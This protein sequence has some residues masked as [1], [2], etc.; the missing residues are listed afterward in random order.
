MS[1]MRSVHEIAEYKP[2]TSCGMEELAIHLITAPV[3]GGIAFAR[4]SD[5]EQKDIAR[6]MIIDLFT[7]IMWPTGLNIL[8]MPGLEWKFERKLLGKRE[9]DWFRK[10]SPHRTYITAIENDRAIYHGGLVNMPGLQ[11]EGSINKVLP[12]TKFA[13][14]VVRNTWVN[15]YFF[16]NVDDLMRE[17]PE[18]HKYDAAWLDYTG[19]MSL[20]RAHL[21]NKFFDN[22]IRSTLVLTNL[23]ARWNAHTSAQI[24]NCGSYESWAEKTF[25]REHELLH[26]IEYQDG[27]SPMAQLAMRK[28]P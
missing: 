23:K 28:R 18:E 14:R 27:P 7:P 24:A 16:G 21:I 26:Y 8:S 12:A 1:T 9:G 20:E 4:K 11:Q 2:L 13:E 22:S 25:L 17:Q 5:R 3:T 10:P 19:P 6:T 15:R